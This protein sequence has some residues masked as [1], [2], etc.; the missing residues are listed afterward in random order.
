MDDDPPRPVWPPIWLRLLLGGVALW[1][2]V[3]IVQ[4]VTES[5]TGIAQGG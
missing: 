4:N 3:R 2:A 5:L 1:L